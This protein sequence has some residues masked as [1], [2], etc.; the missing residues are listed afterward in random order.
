MFGKT[1]GTDF[2]RAISWAKKNGF[3][4]IPD[5]LNAEKNYIPDSS[6]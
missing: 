5:Y 3:C 4:G 2:S 6:S 1:H